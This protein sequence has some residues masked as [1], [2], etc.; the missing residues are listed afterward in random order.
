MEWKKISDNLLP[1]MDSLGNGLVILGKFEK[2]NKFNVSVFIWDPNLKTWL[3]MV[4][5]D[6]DVDTMKTHFQYILVIEEPKRE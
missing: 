4:G 1:M 3:D 2:D 6:W 5:C